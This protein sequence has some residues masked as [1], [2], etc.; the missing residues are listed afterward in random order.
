MPIPLVDLQAQYR[1]IPPEIKAAIE[2]VL[3][4]PWATHVYYVYV[5]QVQARDAFRHALEQAGIATGIH[6]P[7]PIHLQPACA[8][9]GYTTGTLPVTEYVTQHIVSLPLY[10]EL[11]GEQTQLVANAVKKSSMLRDYVS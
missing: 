5:I 4:K 6:Y 3:V 7:T 2:G 8:R 1:S 10:P 11:T 9:Y